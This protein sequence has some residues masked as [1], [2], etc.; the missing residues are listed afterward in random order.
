V[1]LEHQSSDII[2]LSC[3]SMRRPR[4][5]ASDS[6]ELVMTLSGPETQQ[7]RVYCTRPGDLW[8]STNNEFIFFLVLYFARAR[9]LRGFSV[10]WFAKMRSFM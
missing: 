1:K 4:E 8:P 6:I 3:A 9:H 2:P 7:H 10:F 5:A